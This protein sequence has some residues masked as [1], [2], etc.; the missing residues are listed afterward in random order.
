[1]A[2]PDSG[3]GDTAPSIRASRNV[4]SGGFN[5]NGVADDGGVQSGNSGPAVGPYHPGY[6]MSDSGMAD[7]DTGAGDTPTRQTNSGTVN[8]SAPGQ[9]FLS[10]GGNLSGAISEGDR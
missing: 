4:A 2:D 3:T 6:G 10:H 9:V 7:P 1:M 8:W 5:G